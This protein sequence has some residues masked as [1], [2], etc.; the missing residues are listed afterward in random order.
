MRQ[1]ILCTTLHTH[2]YMHVHNYTH[3]FRE[4]KSSVTMTVGCGL[5]HQHTKYTKYAK[6]TDLLQYI[7]F[8]NDFTYGT[9]HS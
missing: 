3:I 7:Q 6:Y 5:V 1:E 2:I 9:I 4:S 8:Y